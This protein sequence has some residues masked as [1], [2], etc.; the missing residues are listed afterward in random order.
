MSLWTKACRKWDENK[1]MWKLSLALA[2]KHYG[3]VHLISDKLGCKFLKNLPFASFSEELESIPNFSSIWSLG[4]IYAYRTAAQNGH[5]LHLDGD[6]FLWEPLPEDLINSDIF[7]QSPDAAFD[8]G[9]Y[10]MN[11]FEKIPKIWEKYKNNSTLIKPY[12]MG[13]FGGRDVKSIQKYCNFVLDMINDPNFKETWENNQ[14]NHVQKAC[15]IEQ[16]NLGIFLYENNLKINTLLKSL[17]DKENLSYKK[18]SH[19]M[20]QKESEVMRQNIIRRLNQNPYN[21]IPKDVPIEKWNKDLN[22]E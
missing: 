8:D 13:I 2:N 7:A 20:P 12:N 19:I 11:S 22:A 6:V 1:S 5:F 14:Q 4:K 3:K 16:G 17:D 15:L 21:L 9:P 10:K 18:Y